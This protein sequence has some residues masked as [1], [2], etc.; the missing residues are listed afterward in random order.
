[1]YEMNV[2][3]IEREIFNILIDKSIKFQYLTEDDIYKIFDLIVK[4]HR[5]Q[6]FATNLSITNIKENDFGE[7]SPVYGQ[8]FLDRNRIIKSYN[9]IYPELMVNIEILHSLFHELRHAMFRKDYYNTSLYYSKD[10]SVSFEYLLNYFC[11]NFQDIANARYNNLTNEDKDYIK[12]L[13]IKSKK[14]YDLEMRDIYI[15]NHC[16]VSQERFCDID[17]LAFIKSMFD[18]Y[19]ITGAQFYEEAKDYIKCWLM[20]ACLSGYTVDEKTHRLITPLENYVEAFRLDKYIDALD[21]GIYNLNK[22]KMLSLN[23]KYRFGL[24]VDKKD[25]KASKIYKR[26]LLNKVEKTRK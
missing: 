3:A 19:G 1:M 26:N 7:Y 14:N 13:G 5:L 25:Y 20:D 16:F 21:E 11:W 15:D 4:H 17:S 22:N 24:A 8:I 9:D 12:L 2:T 18:K 6:K 23:M 10:P